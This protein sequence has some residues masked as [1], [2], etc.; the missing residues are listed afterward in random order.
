MGGMIIRLENIT[1]KYG[2]VNALD[3]INLEFYRGK[4]NILLGPSGAGKTT[5]L[6]IIAGLEKPDT[7]RVYI[8]GVDATDKPP[9]E[10]QVAMVFQESSL[11]PHMTIYDNIAFGLEPLQLDENEVKRRVEYVSGILRIRH[12]L[13][14]YP[15]QLSG[16]EAKRVALARALVVMPKILL[17]DE[18]LSNLDMMLREEL[19][20]ELKRIQRETRITFIY[21]THD[22][23]EALEMGDYIAIIDKGRIIEHG[24][25]VKIYSK[26]SSIEAARFWGHNI[27]E[28]DEEISRILGLTA[29]KGYAII[30]PFYLGLTHGE[31]CTIAQK[32]IR[33]NHAI[34]VLECLDHRLFVVDS[35]IDVTRRRIGERT[36]VEL[37][38]DENDISIIHE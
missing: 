4:I 32:I 6:R 24:E 8:D 38:V 34:I 22:H 19:R 17:L 29:R 5:L 33:R 26:P 20:R 30:P 7:G 16:G 11:F 36:G 14:R 10:R 35:I 2:D 21:V 18:P 9:W 13:H 25:S 27:I 12:L 31:E 1:K 3:N 15:D 28:L 23:D 37:L